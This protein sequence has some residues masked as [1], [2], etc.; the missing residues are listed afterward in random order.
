MRALLLALLLVMPLDGAKIALRSSLD[1]QNWFV[2]TWFH[3][4][5]PASQLRLEVA[6]LDRYRHQLKV[7]H[8]DQLIHSLMLYTPSRKRF[9]AL[10][11]I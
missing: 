8:G 5:V 10:F 7:W 6:F 2:G 9:F 4:P 11:D 3:S 1:G